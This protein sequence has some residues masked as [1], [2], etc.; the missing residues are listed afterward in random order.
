MRKKLIRTWNYIKSISLISLIDKPNK[1]L[2]INWSNQIIFSI[3]KS[4]KKTI[5]LFFQLIQFYNLLE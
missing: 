1:F 3:I 4:I 5:D 2:R